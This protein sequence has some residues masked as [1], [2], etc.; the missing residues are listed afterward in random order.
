MKAIL[1]QNSLMVDSDF[2]SYSDI[3]IENGKIERIS[4]HISK[5]DVP[6]DTQIIDAS[7][8]ILFPG[9]IDAHTHYGL[10]SRGT[11]T[12]DEFNNGS[13]CAAA[14]GCTTVIDFAD[15]NKKKSLLESSMDRIK[16][17]KDMAVDYSLHQGVYEVN[18]RLEYELDELCKNG[19]KALKIFTTYR[20]TGY[21]IENKNDLK[22]LFRCAKER[23]MLVTAHCEDNDIVE[24]IL[25]NWKSDYS[26]SSHPLLRPAEVEKRAIE[27]LS[28]I[29]QSVSSPLYVVHLSSALGL[30]AIRKC[31]SK[32]ANIIAE[33]T[34]TYL[35]KD[36]ALLSRKDSPLFVMTPPL[37][38]KSDNGQLR[39][40]LSNYEIQIVATDHCAFT[41][42]QKL[43]TGADCRSTYPGVP[44][45]AEMAASL[46][47]FSLKSGE[48]DYMH[49]ANLLCSSPAKIFGLY[50]KKGTLKIGSDADIVLFDPNKNW[51][52][53]DDIVSASSYT[54]FTGDEFKGKV[55]MTIHGGD[56]IYDRGKIST[57]KGSGKFLKQHS[58]SIYEKA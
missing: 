4:A 44:G 22:R 53:D 11:V 26:A 54:L 34:P 42:K 57:K 43:D 3:Y 24:D 25:K 36:D 38:K 46:Y 45:T 19:I 1:I 30:D 15:H 27:T 48:I 10:V 52:P 28:E 5:D 41:K 55:A 50:P 18:D 23:E 51:R 6:S 33:T 16:E 49:M 14:G 20:N 40:G 8:L 56:I 21:L 35:Y 12:I 2:M 47:S 17:M 32:G 7:N 58:S 31:R 29:A 39:K 9:F 13:R 37:R